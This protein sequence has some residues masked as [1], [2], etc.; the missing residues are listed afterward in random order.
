MRVR[1]LILLLVGAWGARAGRATTLVQMSLE[2][3]SQ[4]SSVVVRGHAVAQESRWNA[5]HTQ[6]VTLTTIAVEGAIKGSAARTVVVEQPGG[7]VGNIRLRVAG[8]VAFDT[9]GDYFLFLEPA[10]EGTS[11]FLLVGMVQGAYRIYRDSGTGEERVI[12]PLGGLFYGPKGAAAESRTVAPA[13]SL[14]DFR[15]QL[16][17]ALQAPIV[18][19]RGTTLPVVVQGTEFAGA[20][21]VHVLARTT[22]AIFPSQRVVI[23]A[24]SSLEGS[25]QLTAGNWRIHWTEVS[26]RGVRVAISATSQEPAGGFLKGRMLVV[27]VR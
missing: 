10:R 22:S 25:A 5:A 8:T 26:I 18:I 20:G 19:P 24:G 23:P 27:T 21:R 1:I 16:A 3:L 17:D 13:S 14:R 4:A 12:R 9:R 11:R 2:Q 6:I 7:R 15:R